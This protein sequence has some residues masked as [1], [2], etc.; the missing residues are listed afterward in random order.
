MNDE[1]WVGYSKQ[2]IVSGGGSMN[3]GR[4]CNKH[5]G[6]KDCLA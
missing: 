3:Q 2:N 6:G 1:S 5:G 4:I